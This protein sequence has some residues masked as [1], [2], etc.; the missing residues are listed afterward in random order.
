M[1]GF[2]ENGS[3]PSK[4]WSTDRTIGFNEIE[5]ILEIWSQKKN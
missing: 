1:L 2:S 4:K 5:H 3:A